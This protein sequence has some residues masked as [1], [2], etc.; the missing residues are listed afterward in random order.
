MLTEAVCDGPDAIP[1]HNFLTYW[2]VSSPTH[3]LDSMSRLHLLNLDGC[4]VADEGAGHCES[5]NN[6]QIIFSNRQ[7]SQIWGCSPGAGCYRRQFWHCWGSTRR[8]RPSSLSA[9]PASAGPPGEVQRIKNQNHIQGAFKIIL[10]LP[11]ENLPTSF[12]DILPRKIVATVRY[13]APS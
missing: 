11:C 13:L 6:S 12:M 2:I 3:F 5:L 8:R 4:R 9:C 10:N 1:G 7:K